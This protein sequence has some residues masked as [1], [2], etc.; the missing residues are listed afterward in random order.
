MAEQKKI[1]AGKRC[2]AWVSFEINEWIEEKAGEKKWSKSFFIAE[3][4]KDA[5]EKDG[6][7]D[8][9]I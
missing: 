4:L 6:G 2:A 9:K 3:I 1:E 8:V 5:M 7:A